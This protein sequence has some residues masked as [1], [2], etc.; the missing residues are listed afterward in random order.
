MADLFQRIGGNAF[1]LTEILA[2]PSTEV[3]PTVAA[4]VL[5]RVHALTPA[6]QQALQQ[7]SVMPGGARH[8]DVDALLTDAV[9][10]LAEAESPAC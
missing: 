10:P 6:T 4:A 9:T 8:Q 5:S 2:N 1:F 7:L 3:P